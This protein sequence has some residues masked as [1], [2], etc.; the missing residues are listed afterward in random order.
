M[1]KKDPHLFVSHHR[2]ILFISS[3]GQL[4]Q[5]D[6]DAIANLFFVPPGQIVTEAAF[7]G[8]QTLQVVALENGKYA[9]MQ[10]DKYLCAEPDGKTGLRDQANDW[11]SFSLMPRDTFLTQKYLFLTNFQKI[12]P[13]NIIARE[14]HQTFSTLE[15]PEVVKE[16]V[17]SL[18]LANPGWSYNYYSDKDR[19]DFIYQHFGWDVLKLYLR[20]NPRYGACR[21][22]LFRYLCVYQ[23]GGVYL[24][25]KSG[26][27]SPLEN[28]IRPD[29]Q[30]LL[31][32]WRNDTNSQF[33][34]FGNH[35]ELAAIAGG[36]Y[37]QWH[38]IAAAGHGFLEQVILAVLRNIFEYSEDVHGVGVLPVL[39]LT[40]PIV[41]TLTV[42]KY[43]NDF[44]HRFFDSEQAGLHFVA[45]PKPNAA[46]KHYSKQTTPLVL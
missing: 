33:Q 12:A 3:D 38:V 21:A 7:S 17:E 29:D 18:K 5:G 40:G 2:Q 25:I 37:Q 32:Q 14:I 20:I 39:R 9:I 13:S 4:V 30:Y 19:L 31:S 44:K 16:N 23:R 11:E 42:N 41:Y 36:E 10:G 27:S 8:P 1:D 22:D 45:A 15:I 34:H 43:L 26:A 28:F 35:S 24:D 6:E 46:R